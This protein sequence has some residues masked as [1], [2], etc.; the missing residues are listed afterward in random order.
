MINFSSLH[1]VSRLSLC[2]FSPRVSTVQPW[3]GQPWSWVV[4]KRGMRAGA[5]RGRRE[6]AG[7]LLEREAFLPSAPALEFI[8]WNAVNIQNA[9]PVQE[10]S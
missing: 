9:F 7:N 10:F 5:K 4:K 8:G 1:T 3:P 2:C 6:R